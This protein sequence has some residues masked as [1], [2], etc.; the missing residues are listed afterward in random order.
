MKTIIVLFF[1]LSV[2]FCKAQMPGKDPGWSPLMDSTGTEIVKEE[3][4][5]VLI[6]LE[7]AT[8]NDAMKTDIDTWLASMSAASKKNRGVVVSKFEY[9]DHKVNY[10]KQYKVASK[11]FPK[12]EWVLPK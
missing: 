9:I 7:E 8:L 5:L 1:T 12:G 10:D 6:T 2:L 3:K 4:Y 11:N